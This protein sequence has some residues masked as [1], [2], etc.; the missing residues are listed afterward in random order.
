MTHTRFAHERLHAYRAALELYSGVE[1][2]AASFP[3]G[4]ADLKDQL[5]RAVAAT[6]RHIAEGANR[7]QPKDKA[8]RFLLARAEVG[9]CAAAL[10]MAAASRLGA[11]GELLHLADRVAAMC[12]GLIRREERRLIAATG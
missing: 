2:L 7:M 8:A 9:E 5:R 6:V 12:T 10:D 11:Q 1:K 3:R 4:H